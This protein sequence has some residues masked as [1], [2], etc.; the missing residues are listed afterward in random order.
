MKMKAQKVAID[1]TDK[2][3]NTIAISKNVIWV[4]KGNYSLGKIRFSWRVLKEYPTTS[5]A[6]RDFEKRTEVTVPRNR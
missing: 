6:I 5:S 1:L 2:H 4:R 3:K